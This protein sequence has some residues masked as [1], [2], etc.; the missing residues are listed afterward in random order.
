MIIVK[1]WGGL[2]NQMFQYAAARRLAHANGV[3][4]KLDTRWFVSNSSIDTP[5]SYE[6][7]VFTLQTDLATATESRRLGGLDTRRWPKVAKR[8]LAAWGYTPPKSYVVEKHYYF[9]AGILQLK[10]ECY[11]DGYWQSEKY[12]CDAAGLIRNDFT[13]KPI[14]D[15]ANGGLL[16]EINGCESVSLHFRR[17]DYVT[18]ANAAAFHGMIPLDY[19]AA[20]LKTIGVRVTSPRLFVFSD[21]Q[22]WV[23]QNLKTGFPV[24]Y[25]EGNG[26]EKA[27][28][29]MRLM[30][31]CRHH[32]IANSSF[33][34]WGAWLGANPDKTVIAPRNWFI[35]SAVDTCDLIPDSW[36]RL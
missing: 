16:R 6:L 36:V 22:E 14:P 5:R 21:D 3:P 12:F 28:E 34:W 10:D 4:L 32:I 1:L 27:Y 24:T 17:G 30:S 13:V 35:D 33:S 2:G 23:K 15:D 29:D 8:L 20:A 19:Y 26:A 7:D 31:A 18:N 25:V 9:D 11:L